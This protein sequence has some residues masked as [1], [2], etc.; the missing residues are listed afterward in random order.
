MYAGRTMSGGVAGCICRQDDVRGCDSVCMPPAGFQVVWQGVYADLVKSGLWQGV[1]A[2]RTI[3]GAAARCT[4]RF[5]D[6]KWCGRVYM[7]PT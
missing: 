5:G 3:S 4:C 1:H 2:A 7:P 6:E